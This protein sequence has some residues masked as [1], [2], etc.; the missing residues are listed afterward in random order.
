MHLA[1]LISYIFPPIYQ[2]GVCLALLHV[3]CTQFI[4]DLLIAGLTA[5]NAVKVAARIFADGH[6]LD[7]EGA[8][9]IAEVAFV[10]GRG[11]VLGAHGFA[12]F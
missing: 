3:L 5:A 7:G 4:H 11:G 6:A 8:V 9:H 1:Y 2:W 12:S 10:L